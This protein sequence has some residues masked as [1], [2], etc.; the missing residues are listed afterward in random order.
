MA[1]P[2]ARVCRELQVGI[3]ERDWVRGVVVAVE[4]ASV[5]VQVDD[6]GRYTH[7]L[8]GVEVKHGAILRDNPA[9]WVPCLADPP[10]PRRAP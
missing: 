7:T 10:A 6:P 8:N 3:A 1:K 5:N 9:N 2:G 4:G